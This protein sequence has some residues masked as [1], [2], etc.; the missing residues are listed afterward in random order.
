MALSDKVY[1]IVQRYSRRVPPTL[2]AD[3]K[4][5]ILEEFLQLERVVNQIADSSTQVVE[6]LPSAPRIGQVVYFKDVVLNGITQ[7]GLHVY[8]SSGWEKISIE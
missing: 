6:Q 7:Q 5:Y 4:R 3:I 1:Q 2:D 8:G